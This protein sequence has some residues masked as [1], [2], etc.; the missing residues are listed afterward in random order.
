M[1]EAAFCGKGVSGVVDAMEA[2]TR[3]AN[4]PCLAHC[5]WEENTTS[6]VRSTTLPLLSSIGAVKQGSVWHNTGLGIAVS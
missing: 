2:W 1:L 3:L 5:P 4:I 6:Y